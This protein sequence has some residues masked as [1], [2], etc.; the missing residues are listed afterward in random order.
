MLQSRFG[1]TFDRYSSEDDCVNPIVGQ[2][3]IEKSKFVSRFGKQ[4]GIAEDSL[5]AE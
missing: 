2:C 3:A 4:E 1:Y 5:S